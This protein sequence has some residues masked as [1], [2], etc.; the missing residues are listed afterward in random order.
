[1]LGLKLDYYKT[2]YFKRQGSI[3]IRHISNGA[4]STSDDSDEDD[5]FC[6]LKYGEHLES[7][8][9]FQS[10]QQIGAKVYFFKI[11][12]IQ[13]IYFINWV[14]LFPLGYDKLL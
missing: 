2:V 6:V 10:A 8:P 13:N 1:M 4:T 7:N 14:F 12:L 5:S 3:D 11:N 9:I